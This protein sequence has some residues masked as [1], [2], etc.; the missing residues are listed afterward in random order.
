MNERL[1]ST[2]IPAEQALKILDDDVNVDIR[3]ATLA[4]RSHTDPISNSMRA[5]RKLMG[6][7]EGCDVIIVHELSCFLGELARRVGRAAVRTHGV[8]LGFT[9]RLAPPQVDADAA[10]LVLAAR[11]LA[12]DL[13]VGAEFAQVVLVPRRGRGRGRRVR[14]A[15]A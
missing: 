3:A 1:R 5:T 12:V 13:A 6:N 8:L 9:N 4:S 2:S 10:E 7:V 11:Y 14:A 15:G